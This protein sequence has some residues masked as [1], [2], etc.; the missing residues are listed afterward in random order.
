MSSIRTDSEQA[1]KYYLAGFGADLGS[2]P[3]SVCLWK[4]NSKS[5]PK[6]YVD[7]NPCV[8][9]HNYHSQAEFGRGGNLRLTDTHVADYLYFATIVVLPPI[10]TFKS[11]SMLPTIVVWPLI[12]IFFLVNNWPLRFVLP[13]TERSPWATISTVIE[14]KEARIAIDIV[15]NPHSA[16]KNRKWCIFKGWEILKRQISEYRILTTVGSLP[17]SVTKW[18]W[19]NKLTN[20]SGLT[21]KKSLVLVGRWRCTD[22][23]HRWFR[24]SSISKYRALPASKARE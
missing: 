14:R 22:R 10:V 20:Y 18:G 17:E 8:F 6:L 3:N 15:T 11:A 24:I 16:G 9:W 2:T 13:L 12:V 19:S 7:R 5:T 4:G 1:L 23:I 21:H